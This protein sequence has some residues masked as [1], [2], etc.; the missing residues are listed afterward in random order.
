MEPFQNLNLRRLICIVVS[1]HRRER[2]EYL[3]ST[4]PS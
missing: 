4:E 1:P 2:T 3:T